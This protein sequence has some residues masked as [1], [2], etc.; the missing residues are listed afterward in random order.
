MEVKQEPHRANRFFSVSSMTE[1]ISL[2]VKRFPI[3]ISLVVGLAALFFAA[4]N[5]ENDIPYQ[6]WIFFSVG[7]FISVTATLFA[8]DFF[9]NLKTY[10]I[11]L[12]VVLFWGVYC[13]LLPEDAQISK[14]IEIFV[15]GGT[16]FLSMLFI[17]F[18]KK[19]KDRAF[20]NFATQT[21]FQMAL[22]CV[23]GMII[24]G[25][26]SLALLA[27]NSLFNVLIT[28]KMYGNLAVICFVLFSPIYFL[29]NIPN[30]TEKQNNEISHTKVQKILTLYILTPVLAVYAVILYA[31][32]LK[33]IVAW[34]L[35]NGWVSWLV[36]VLSLGGLLVITILYP[37]CEQEKNRA[38][39]FISRWFGLLIL[40]L[41]ALMTIG[42]LRRISDYGITINRGY[43][44]LL[45]IWFYGIY[46]YLFFSQSRRIQWILV[47]FAAVAFLASVSVWGV[48]NVTQNSLTKEV[49]TVLNKQVSFKE[50]RVI[51]AEM[52]QEE[53][54]RMKSALEYL[55]RHFGKES[56]QPFFTDAVPD[57]YY[58]D[59]L[60]EL[61][62]GDDPDG[63]K[64]SIAYY[65]NSEKVWE[66]SGYRTFTR[67]YNSGYGTTSDAERSHKKNIIEI[68]VN[69]RSFSIPMREI[70]LA[71]LATEE[72]L[73]NEQE[74]IVQG[75]DYAVLISR[76]H[77]DYYPEKDRIVIHSLDG[78]LLCK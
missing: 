6:F 60:S 47:S 8:E 42:I 52:T 64:E 78:Y 29:A 38:A 37:V 18:L 9:D 70:A 34:E 55:D 58:W 57:S 4:V 39:S 68:S 15:I 45:N 56:V 7:T 2:L 31:Y 73:R 11:S 3:G 13:F 17:S 40:P 1:K 71:Y 54:G 36:S 74:W 67:I 5:S 25:G 12:F 44:L 21:L 33:I 63:K 69:G 19:N 51:F 53:K 75:N 26:L 32:L 59:F 14:A 41:L 22:A 43:I 20:W 10:G 50:A 49:S 23:F 28:G 24:F 61:G 76:L 62:L 27:I 30:K 46:I 16:A 48:A 35:P 65:A 66:I 77:G 72:K